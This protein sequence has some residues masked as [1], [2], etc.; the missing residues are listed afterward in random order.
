MSNTFSLSLLAV[1]LLPVTALA[2]ETPVPNPTNITIA[3]ADQAYTQKNTGTHYTP[4]YF[5]QYAPRTATDML[6]RIPGYGLRSGRGR[7]RG[8]GQG[9]A[10]VLINGARISGKTSAREQLGRIPASSIIE[11][12]IID[13]AS[14]HIPGLTGQVANLI[15]NTQ[16][17]TG[18]WAWNP[19]FRNH[20][21]PNLYDGEISVSGESGALTYAASLQSD[22]FR[23]GNVTTKALTDE[24]G[25]LYEI[26]NGDTDVKG[27]ALIGAVDLSWAPR[28][29]QL[30]SLNAKYKTSN[31]SRNSV[32]HRS[33]LTERGSTLQAISGRRGDNWKTEI[34]ADYERPALF[35]KLKLIGFY[36]F[37]HKPSRSDFNTYDTVSHTEGSRY[38]SNTDRAEAIFRSEFSWVNR[39]KNNWQFDVEG[40]FNSLDHTASL[41]D[42]NLSTAQYEIDPDLDNLRTRVE[43]K[44]AETTLSYTRNLSSK[45]D[46][47]SSLGAEYSELLQSELSRKFFRLKGFI[48]SSYKPSSTFS[49]RTKIARDVGQLN[50]GDFLSSVNLDDGEENTGNAN[51]VPQQSWNGQIEFDKDLGNGNRFKFRINGSKISDIVDRIPLGEDGDAVGNIDSAHTIAAHISTTLKGDQWGADGTQLDIAVGLHDSSVEDP[52][53]FFN[54]DISRGEK[55]HWNVKFRHDIPQTKW[56]YGGSIGE[57]HTALT[58][59]LETISHNT[60]SKPRAGVFLEHKDV[61]GMKAR[62]NLNNILNALD[63]NTLIYY[64]ARRDIG[65]FDRTEFLSQRQGTSV[66]FNLSGTF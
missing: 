43:E 16:G 66:K 62:L 39:G 13:G 21:A 44:R 14:A 6:S 34:G 42:L 30:V 31:L 10:N 8:L 5:H 20:R 47:Q 28:T 63:E 52:L 40:A 49:I 56:A 23:F 60:R 19:Q 59:R 17:V 46:I 57:H 33:A 1:T 55:N 11:I 3:K 37:S 15:I 65:V 35:G 4:A 50:F 18:T 2:L 22:P 45:L 27:N 51:L 12:I 58:Y 64:T 53:L 9:G 7:R 38:I 61:F 48:S 29:D 54:R 36:S 25:V 24:D 41:F 26:R 32:S